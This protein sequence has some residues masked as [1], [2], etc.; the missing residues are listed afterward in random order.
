MS[1]RWTNTLHSAGRGGAEESPSAARG[2][3]ECLKSTRKWP[4][5]CTVTNSTVVVVVVG[6]HDQLCL[7]ATSNTP[8]EHSM[9]VYN[10]WWGTRY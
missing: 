5:S 1:L 3:I 6:G 10:Y 8:N 7:M 4:F 9:I 2:A